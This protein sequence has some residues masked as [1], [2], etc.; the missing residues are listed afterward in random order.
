M[1]RFSLILLAVSGIAQAIGPAAPANP[2]ASEIAAVVEFPLLS[3]GVATTPPDVQAAIECAKVALD[4][5]R[6][7]IV[8]LRIEGIDSVVWV[9]AIQ[10][11]S[12]RR[13]LLQHDDFG[14]GHTTNQQCR[15]F[16]F[17]KALLPLGCER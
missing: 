1:T 6:A 16:T 2:L 4:Q 10:L 14:S 12:G 11:P 9:A 7:F 3:C 17:S 8:Q 15:G 13:L 5:R